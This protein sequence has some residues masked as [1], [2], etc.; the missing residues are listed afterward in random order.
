MLIH[1]CRSELFNH[2]SLENGTCRGAHL[3]I[4]VRMF[5]HCNHFPSRGR[6]TKQDASKFWFLAPG[7]DRGGCPTSAGFGG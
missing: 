6:R 2:R 5:T 1:P 3:M 7:K 4:T